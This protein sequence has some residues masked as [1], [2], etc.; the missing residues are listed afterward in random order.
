VREPLTFEALSEAVRRMS[1]VKRNVDLL[2]HYETFDYAFLLPNTKSVG[3]EAFIRR[4]TKAVSDEPLMPGAL[5]DCVEMTFGSACI[6]EDTLEL[7]LLLS[8]A[9]VAKNAAQHSEAQLVF[10]HELV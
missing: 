1:R 5:R 4:I 6:P 2:S 7:S 8:A 3:V 9:E 10:Y